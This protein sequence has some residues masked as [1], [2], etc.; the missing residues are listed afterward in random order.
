[1][2]QSLN[3]EP[4]RVD[5]SSQSSRA[6]EV[7]AANED[8]LL[9]ALKAL[10]SRDLARIERDILGLATQPRPPGSEKLT[11]ADIYRI[12]RGN[13][14]IVYKVYDDERVVLIGGVLRRN[15]RTYR[16]PD[17]LFP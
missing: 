1:M 13:F 7:R 8:R 14:R 10:P 17:A 12:R 11:G 16:D 4:G 2:R 3:T 6:Y 5:P 9:R 15:E